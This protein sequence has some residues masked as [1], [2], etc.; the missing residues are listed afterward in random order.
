MT[1]R[2][3]VTNKKKFNQARTLSSIAKHKQ[4]TTTSISAGS[5]KIKLN[6]N[7]L[8]NNYKL[9]G[10]RKIIYDLSQTDTY[11]NNKSLLI[12]HANRRS[13]GNT[14]GFERLGLSKRRSPR[15]VNRWYNCTNT[16]ELDSKGIGFFDKTKHTNSGRKRLLSSEQMWD[17]FL[18]Y[19][20]TMQTMDTG[21]YTFA[22]IIKKKYNYLSNNTIVRYIKIFTQKYKKLKQP[23]KLPERTKKQRLAH[24]KFWDSLG[25]KYLKQELASIDETTV[26]TNDIPCI[27]TGYTPRA[28]INSYEE[29]CNVARNNKFRENNNNNIN[30]PEMVDNPTLDIHNWTMPPI[31]FER[32][33][34]PGKIV[35]IYILFYFILFLF[36]FFY[37][38]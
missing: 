20:N 30:T 32:V 2:N 22:K 18:L 35:Y 17:L 38:I 31:P 29:F 3:K 9:S 6:K 8:K 27:L 23:K 25:I 11:K 16:D 1:S 33:C 19:Y 4:T 21:I 28:D 7:K 15:F 26:Y 14:I 12:K 36:F 34:T 24:C 5:K 37:F 10:D 13:L